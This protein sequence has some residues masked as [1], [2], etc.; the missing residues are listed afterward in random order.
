[1]AAAGNTGE[2][3]KKCFYGEHMA[4]PALHAGLHLRRSPQGCQGTGGPTAG[5]K[6][7]G[8]ELAGTGSTVTC[9]S[10]LSD[11]HICA[12][13]A[14]GHLGRC[15]L[16]HVN[17]SD[18]PSKGKQKMYFQTTTKLLGR[19]MHTEAAFDGLVMAA[20]A[21]AAVNSWLKQGGLDGGV[22][23]WLRPTLKAAA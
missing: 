18:V 9:I 2:W 20:L 4:A 5:T 12:Q 3:A 1:M 15:H 21:L 7:E 17:M 23:A 8:A 22:P 11:L 10:A 6:V 19:A 14:S 13:Q 16:D